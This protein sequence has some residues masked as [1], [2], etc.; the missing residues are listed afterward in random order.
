MGLKKLSLLILALSLGSACSQN[1]LGIGGRYDTAYLLEPVELCRNISGP[2]RGCFSIQ[3][4]L[5]DN[6]AYVD[7]VGI[8]G[9]LANQWLRVGARTNASNPEELQIISGDQVKSNS[10]VAIP[11]SYI[12]VAPSGGRNITEY[13]EWFVEATTASNTGVGLT[14]VKAPLG[15]GTKAAHD[16]I[17]YRDLDA[18]LA[19]LGWNYY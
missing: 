3:V 4:S 10:F 19:E 11:E 17:T 18:V 15:G 12:I 7:I 13:T 2:Q 6:F 1:R 9:D 5:N 8:Q 16:F 14:P